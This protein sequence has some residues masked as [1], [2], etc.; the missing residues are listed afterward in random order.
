M[1]GKSNQRAGK[2]HILTR[3]LPKGAVPFG[4]LMRPLW[5]GLS[6]LPLPSLLPLPMYLGRQR[7]EGNL[8]HVTFEAVYLLQ[9]FLLNFYS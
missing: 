4:L 3:P 2:G 6:M 7:A 9:A 8:V 1:V 5:T